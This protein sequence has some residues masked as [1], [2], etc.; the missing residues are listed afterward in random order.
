MEFTNKVTDGQRNIYIVCFKWVDSKD[1]VRL[2]KYP[3][4]VDKGN[5]QYVTYFELINTL[6]MYSN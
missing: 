1:T 6:L 2:H 4:F 3:T 5:I